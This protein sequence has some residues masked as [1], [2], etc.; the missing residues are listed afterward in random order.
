MFKRLQ[1][2]KH[3]RVQMSKIQMANSALVKLADT[4]MNIKTSYKVL[5]LSKSMENE[6]KFY[7]E[8]FGKILEKYA[9][10]KEDGSFEFTDNGQAVK[11]KEGM[12]Q[13]AQQEIFELENLEVE[14]PDIRFDIDELEGLE[15][16]P[17]EL[18]AIEDFID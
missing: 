5:K 18:I 6:I 10:K 8:E 4:K 2:E 3:M 7:G 17:R 13:Q 11:I 12:D 16:T 15:L 14:I 9:V 1:E